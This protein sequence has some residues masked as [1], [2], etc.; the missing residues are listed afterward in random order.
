MLSFVVFFLDLEQITKLVS[1]TNLISY[2][3]VNGAV[4]SLRFREPSQADEV[5]LERSSNEKWVW[6]YMF[7]AF[8]STGSIVHEWGTV[9]ACILGAAVIANFVVLCLCE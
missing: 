2:S 5:T 7:L 9:W 6:S 4:I 8:L 3:I 1:L